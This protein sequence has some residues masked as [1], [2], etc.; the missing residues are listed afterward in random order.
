MLK[1][2]DL[3]NLHTSV[4]DFF[5]E[6]WE[7]AERNERRLLGKN[8][9]PKEE[10]I[11]KS[12][13]R[14][15]YSM[16]IAASYIQRIIGLQRQSQ[17]NW[18][19][20]PKVNPEEE[21]K[22]EIVGATLRAFEREEQ[23]PEKES[24]VFQDGLAISFGVD[25][26][27]V[28]EDGIHNEVVDYRN[29][30]WDINSKKDDLS[31]ALFVC[32]IERVYKYQLPKEFQNG[33]SSYLLG[34]PYKNYFIQER[35]GT[36]QRDYDL[37]SV[38]HHYQR[39]RKTFYTVYI[40][41][42]ANLLKTSRVKYFTTEES[43][44]NFIDKGEKLYIAAGIPYEGE[45][46][47]VVEERDVWDYYKFTYAGIIEYK[48][49]NWK[50]HPYNIYR[51]IKVKNN[52]TS[53]LD[54]VSSPQLMI[55][56]LVAQIDYSLKQELKQVYELNINAL[57]EGETPESATEKMSKTGGVIYTKEGKAI[58]PAAVTGINPQYLQ[59]ISVIGALT[60]EL[61]GG[62]NSLGL[63]ESTNESGRAIQLRQQQG[64]LVAN[65]YLDRFKSYKEYKGRKL[66]YFLSKQNKPRILRVSQT[67]MPLRVRA[68]LHQRGI[69]APSEFDQ[70]VGYLRV[71]FDRD[72]QINHDDFDLIVDT[73]KASD[74]EK[75]YKLNLFLEAERTM[76]VLQ[77]SRTFQAEK[78]KTLSLPEDIIEKI[79]T[80]MNYAQQAIQPGEGTPQIQNPSQEEEIQ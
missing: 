3:I 11:I 44:I 70:S 15:P 59:L 58:L 73:V 34:R 6:K 20:V 66:L 45:F 21:L 30:V 42:S 64:L 74:T 25:K 22:A 55:D 5:V 8:W 9:T 48:E 4:A 69:L 52:W 78:L 17:L 12:Q 27:V 32:E 71:G 79:L 72:T 50:Y 37:V 2:N 39:T 80:E 65:L 46:E 38:F 36:S 14:T 13:G 24:E 60:T 63:P 68:R 31:D 47:L 75:E 57:A 41:D 76:P 26:F 61:L 19:V 10:Q 16:P 23:I 29:F 77:Q 1:L 18:K 56:K 51:A 67:Q 49:L 54:F 40:K 28:G 43:A 62:K 7:V 35:Q 53:L 33:D